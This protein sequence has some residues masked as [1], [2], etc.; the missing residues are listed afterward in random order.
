MTL[1]H[2]RDVSDALKPRAPPLPS[3]IALRAVEAAV[4]RASFT[5]AADELGVTHGA[6]SRHVRSLE[7]TLGVELFERT[8][9]RVVP[10]YTGRMLGADLTPLFA[11]IAEAV[12]NVRRRPER[13][14]LR[15]SVGPTFASK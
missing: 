8:P 12:D 5:A 1:L 11:G 3:L 13:L 6:V 2:T 7:L 15:L 9:R 10:T 4:R 14:S